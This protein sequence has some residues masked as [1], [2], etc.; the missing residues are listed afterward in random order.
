MTPYK[1][2]VSKIICESLRPFL[3]NLAAIQLY[4]IECVFAFQT[5][6]MKESLIRK[7]CKDDRNN[8][9][10]EHMNSLL[11]SRSRRSPRGS[12][13]FRWM[14]LVGNDVWEGR[15]ADGQLREST[16]IHLRLQEIWWSAK[17]H[18]SRITATSISFRSRATSLIRTA[19]STGL[20]SQWPI[21]TI[22][23]RY[24]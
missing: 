21:A 18:S 6:G 1:L 16:L 20:F 5:K 3:I 8:Y 2:C 11:R 12:Y 14:F 9:V 17:W 19:L 7:V 13:P 22:R 10:L 4:R 15:C 23:R 24:P